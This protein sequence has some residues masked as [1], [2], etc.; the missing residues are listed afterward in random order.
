MSET[1]LTYIQE[2][3]EILQKIIQDFDFKE[4]QEQLPNE[5]RK[6][7]IL[8]TGSSLNAALA[9][10]CYF[11]QLADVTV[12]IEEPYH[13]QHY[14]HFD[15]DTDLVIA[16]SQSGKSTSTINVLKEIKKQQ[17]KSFALTSNLVSP[18]VRDTN[19]TLDL[20]IGIEKVGYVTKG[21]SGTVL[22]LFLLALGIAARKQVIFKEK[23]E[24]EIQDLQCIVGELLTLIPR[25]KHFFEDN[26]ELFVE[27]SRLVCIGYGA[28]YGIA[29]EFETKFT[30]TT[31]LPSTG[32]EL[33]AYMH[34][35]YLEAQAT[36]L[37]FFFIDASKNRQRAIK[38]RDYMKKHVGNT[39]TVVDT[40][41]SAAS[42]E[43]SLNTNC[44]NLL[45]LPL[46]YVVV[47]QTW[48]YQ[49]ATSMGIDL[50]V[51]PFPDFDEALGSKLI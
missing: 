33:E 28:N 21:F 1:M 20:N 14:G 12:T 50:S 4:L 49:L 43:F 3:P 48:S 44:Q 38:L 42:F 47:A 18:L 2:E 6:L 11:E 9:A 31:R 32:F 19:Y 13:F 17:V 22:N 24:S 8:A 29:K 30:E 7:L 34:G 41:E 36:H 39:I 46:L 15:S 40:K 5:V 16:I 10:K 23:F 25:V 51:D 37:L 45:L 26:Q 27:Y 35:P